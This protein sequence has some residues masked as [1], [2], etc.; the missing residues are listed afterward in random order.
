M[1]IYFLS[2]VYTSCIFFPKDQFI[3]PEYPTGG[4]PQKQ[5]VCIMSGERYYS[6]LFNRDMF[7]LLTSSI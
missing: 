2:I 6:D 7:P 5:S 3:I 4:M 1:Y